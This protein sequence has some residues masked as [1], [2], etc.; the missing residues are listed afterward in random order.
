MAVARNPNEL[1]MEQAEVASEDALPVSNFLPPSLGGTSIPVEEEEDNIINF[2]PTE[3]GGVEVEFSDIQE[4]MVISGPMGS[5]YENLAEHLSDEDLTEIGQNVY[6]SYESDK[7]SREEWEQI[8]ER[9]F[10][11]LGLKLEE[12]TEPFDGACTAVHPLLIESVV[13]FQSKASQ[14]LFPSG[15]PV[16]AQILGS[17]TLD[18]EHQA[19]R[20]QQFMNYQLTQQMPEYFE[21]QERLLFHLP[22]MGSAFKKIYYDQLLERPV[23]ELVPVDHFYVSYNAKDLRTADRYTH[24]IFRSV[25]D[26][27]KDVVSGMYLDIDL[28]KP[29]SPDLPEITQKMDEIMGIASSGMDLEDP[30]YV[31]L[32]QHC[33]LDLP[34]PYNDPDGIAHPYIVTIEENTQKVLCIRRNYKEDDPKK[35]KKLHF[36]HY[37]Y[38]PGFGFYGLGLIHF[39]GNLTMTATTAMR[40]LVDAGQFANLPG[41]FKARGVRLVGDNDPIAPGEFKEVESTGIDLNKAI[42]TLPYKEPSQTLMGMMQFIIG[43]GQK[44]ADSTEQ[45]I[46]DSTNAGPVGTTMA[47]LEASSKFFTA[48]H[49]RLHKAQKDEFEVLAQINYDYLPPEYPYEVIGGDQNI[50]KQDFDGRV[51]IVPVS[52]PNIPSSAHRL[53]LGQMAIQL[54][55][56]TPP[57][58]FNMPALYRQVLSAANFP[59][60]DEVL[61]PEQKPEP[62]DPL[63]DIMTAA[64]GLPIAAFPGQNHEAHIQFKSAF[65]KDPGTGANPMMQQIVPIINANIRDHMLMKYQEQVIG[66]AEASGVANDPQTSEMVMAQAA[67]EVAN[68]NAAM[69]VVHSPEQQMLILEKDRLAFDKEKAQMETFKESAD[70]ALK[71]R[72]MDLREKE[73]LSEMV[74]NIG[75]LENEERRDSLKALEATA[76][77]E[78]EKEKIDGDHE[79]KAANIA[80]SN[81]LSLGTKLKK[82]E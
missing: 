74:M 5:H 21:E 57:G 69:G 58:T 16:K 41:G 72:D 62:R 32:E 37:R 65:L 75:K 8:F 46:S 26:Y 52:D 4:E 7:E 60:L 81:L 38:V 66:L 17:Y 49:K 50:F 23:S 68:A 11:L 53:A 47:L 63:A 36:I 67:E 55:A 71:Q 3:D 24:M 61:P 33:Y 42:I 15:G 59:N 48:I 29:S 18:R 9:G 82:G 20:V 14:E 39:L 64:K 56:Q 51:D 22:V 79:I 30:L 2:M 45:I 31:L 10:D 12:T 76:K 25:N 1:L 78:L 6:D 19:Q 40:S 73:S 35:E 28:G 77:M 43:A 44:F 27:K 34:E 80:L 54:A 13:K 70:I